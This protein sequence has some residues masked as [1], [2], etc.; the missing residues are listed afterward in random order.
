MYARIACATVLGFVTLMRE[1]L[2]LLENP[3][4]PLEPYQGFQ[5]VNSLVPASIRDSR[6]IHWKGKLFSTLAKA[7]SLF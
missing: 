6:M 7:F 3:D 2:L 5:S 1:L 4:M